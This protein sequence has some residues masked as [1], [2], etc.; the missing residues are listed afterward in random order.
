ME[1][2]IRGDV[3]RSSGDAPTRPWLGLAIALTVTL[4]LVGSEVAADTDTESEVG[5][6]ASIVLVGL[7]SGFMVA[8]RPRHPISWLLTFAAISGGLAAL[9]AEV[10]PPGVTELTWWQAILA[11]ISGPTWLGL[12]FAVLVLIPLLFPTGSPTSPRWRWVGWLGGA[13]LVVMSLMSMTQESFCTHWSSDDHCLASVDNPIGITG[14]PN[15]EQTATG[16]V[17]FGL[18]LICAVAALISLIIRYR[19]SG[20]VQRHQ[21]KWVAFSLGLYF[22]FSLVVDGLWGE[23]LG[24]PLVGYWVWVIQQLLWVLIPASIAVAILRYRLYEIDRIV[25]RTVSYAVIAVVLAAVYVGGVLS[26]QTVLPA[27]DELAV[28]ASTLVAA[29][30]FSPLRRR[31]QRWVDRR[32]NRSR[33]DAAEIVEA[34][35]SRLRDAVDLSVVTRDLGMVVEETVAPATAA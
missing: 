13:A 32:F 1:D 29:A 34:F 15:P 33:Y 8:K 4:M 3:A 28:A 22:A 10:L 31:V 24:R 6:A 21:I 30:L 12:L 7:I 27:S 16:A 9:S 26:V 23:V 20:P 18:L 19:R 25:S 17:F 14:I 2:T 35:S 5:I 11:I